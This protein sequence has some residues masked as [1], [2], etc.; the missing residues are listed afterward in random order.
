MNSSLRI[1]YPHP[2]IFLRMFGLDDEQRYRL[3]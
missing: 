1:G 3:F 2:C